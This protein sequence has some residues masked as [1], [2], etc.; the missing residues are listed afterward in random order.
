MDKIIIIEDV[1][2]SLPDFLAMEAGPYKNFRY[3]NEMMG[4]QFR[5]VNLSYKGD[6]IYYSYTQ[7]VVKRNGSAYYLKQG[8]KAGFTFENRKLKIWWGKNVQELPFLMPLFKELKLDWFEFKMIKYLTKGLFEKMLRGD[9]T[10]PIDYCKAYL[11]AVRMKD[12]SPKLFYD[13]V[14]S[15]YVNKF[16]LFSAIEVAKDPN[17]YLE[18]VNTKYGAQQGY[19]F[20]IMVQDLVRQGIILGRKIDFLWSEKRMKLLHDEWTKE[21]MN[22]EGENIDDKPLTNLKKFELMD[23]MTL[24]DSQKKVWTEGKTMSHCVYT[25]YWSSIKNGSY[26]AYHLE[27]DNETA[28][29]G[30]NIFDDGKIHFNQMY[31][32]HNSVVSDILKARVMNWMALINNKKQLTPLL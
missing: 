25:N 6:T 24:L 2:S 10:N 32:K 4:K 30:V 31:G 27:I 12:V 23:G 1:E 7:Y 19:I 8:N 21:I 13:A 17:H 29:L 16:E 9:I 11:K 22:L 18:K 15:E 14:R 26:Q 28:T 20:N 3:Q 5:R